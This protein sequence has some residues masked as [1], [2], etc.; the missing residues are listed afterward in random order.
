MY[1]YIYSANQK[2]VEQKDDSK[3]IITG[4]NCIRNFS[5]KTCESGIAIV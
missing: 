4:S 1:I 5:V 2:T 3:A